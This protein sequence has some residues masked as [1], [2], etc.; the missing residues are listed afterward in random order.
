MAWW[1]GQ[2][3]LG[4]GRGSSV[5]SRKSV[6]VRTLA[7]QEPPVLAACQWDKVGSMTGA[8]RLVVAASARRRR[9]VG[10]RSGRWPSG[11]GSSPF[12]GIQTSASKLAPR[13]CNTKSSLTRAAQKAWVARAETKSAPR[14]NSSYGDVVHAGCGAGAPEEECAEAGLAGDEVGELVHRPV[15]VQVEQG[16]AAVGQF[17]AACPDGLTTVPKKV[18]GLAAVGGKRAVRP[19]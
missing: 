2:P 1:P 4:S 15:P 11:R 14:W 8:A 16:A 13:A 10:R 3:W 18:E 12:L 17:P 5:P 9:H 7:R 6:A 19:G